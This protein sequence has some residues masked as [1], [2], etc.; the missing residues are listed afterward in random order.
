[1]KKISILCTLLPCTQVFQALR[2]VS[3]QI[4][5]RSENTLTDTLPLLHLSV[6]GVHFIF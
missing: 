3:S 2:K 6:N 4:I 5:L 1:M